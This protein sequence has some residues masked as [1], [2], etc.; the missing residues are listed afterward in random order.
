MNK[1]GI[2]NKKGYFGTWVSKFFFSEFTTLWRTTSLWIIFVV[3]DL[4]IVE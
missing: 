2:N 3:F 4:I 1:Y